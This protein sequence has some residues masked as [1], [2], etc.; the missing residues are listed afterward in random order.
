MSIAIDSL[1]GIPLRGPF[2]PIRE[3]LGAPTKTSMSP[4]GNG[5]RFG[6]YEWRLRTPALGVLTWIA[7]DGEWVWGVAQFSEGE[8]D[9]QLG[10]GVG[11]PRT[12]VAR[13]LEIQRV[14]V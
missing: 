13:L 14:V 12:E 5:S 10:F 1:I 6:F 4:E 11:S 7:E 3:K 8:P 2:A 9:P